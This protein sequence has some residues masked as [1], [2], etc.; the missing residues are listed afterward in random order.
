MGKKSKAQPSDT[1]IAIKWAVRVFVLGTLILLVV[2]AYF[3]YQAK[4]AAEDTM[5]A[6]LDRYDEL[7][8]GYI[9]RDH[10]L[11]DLTKGDPVIRNGQPSELGSDRVYEWRGFFRTYGIRVVL[12]PP[13]ND[14]FGGSPIGAIEWVE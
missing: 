10:Q 1:Q 13:A 12:S 5:D 2:L 6:W 9:M 11:E 14:S 3:D 8:D 7:A 4:T